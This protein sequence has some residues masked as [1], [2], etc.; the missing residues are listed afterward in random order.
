LE[1]FP[2]QT[3]ILFPNSFFTGLRAFLLLTTRFFLTTR[4]FL[5]VRR[6]RETRRLVEVR[7]LRETRLFVDLLRLA[8]ILIVQI[9]GM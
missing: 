1:A 6:F 3:L 9:K 2:F 5:D 4:R 7:R 8:T